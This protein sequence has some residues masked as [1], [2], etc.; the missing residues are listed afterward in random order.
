MRK[1]LGYKQTM[2]LFIELI[3]LNEKYALA[4]LNYGIFL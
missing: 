1:R 4:C 2:Y 3:C